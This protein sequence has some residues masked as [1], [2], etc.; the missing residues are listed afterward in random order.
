MKK[1]IIL[2]GISDESCASS[3]TMEANSKCHLENFRCH[4]DLAHGICVHLTTVT[5]YFKVTTLS[6]GNEKACYLLR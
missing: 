6:R 1:Q 3:N 2:S 4:G 5:L